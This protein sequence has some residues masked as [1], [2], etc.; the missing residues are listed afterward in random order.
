MK[1]LHVLANLLLPD[2]P[3]SVKDIECFLLRFDAKILAGPLT[4]ESYV[5]V[6]WQSNPTRLISAQWDRDL[7]NLM[8]SVIK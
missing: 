1:V 3:S 8:T 7:G 2:H 6:V 5:V 4:T